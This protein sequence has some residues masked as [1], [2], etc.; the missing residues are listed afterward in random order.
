MNNLWKS[1]DAIAIKRTGAEREKRPRKKTHISAYSIS[2]DLDQQEM[3]WE[4]C[5]CS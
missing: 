4:A 5:S 3:K 2:M 1:S